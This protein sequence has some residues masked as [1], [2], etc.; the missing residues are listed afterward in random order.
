[1]KRPDFLVHHKGK[2]VALEVKNWDT[3]NPLK[4]HGLGVS[5]YDF[6]RSTVPR[7]EN[8]PGYEKYIVIGVL[9]IAGGDE[10]K[11]EVAEKLRENRIDLIDLR[12]NFNEPNYKDFMDKWTVAYYK[13]RAVLGEIIL[14]EELRPEERPS[15]P[16]FR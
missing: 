7:F 4:Y 2:K 1:M 14:A 11:K 9:K 16:T 10:G 12:W 5:P 13:L 15:D 8:Y 3:A 6:L